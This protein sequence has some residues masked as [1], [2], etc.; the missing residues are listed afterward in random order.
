MKITIDKTNKTVTVHFAE[1]IEEVFEFLTTAGID[2]K[3]YRLIPNSDT[4]FVPVSL[5]L[6]VPS[7]PNY[8]YY[9]PTLPPYQP[10][11]TYRPGFITY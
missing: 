7:Y 8:P 1:N 4:V 3:E 5:P 2:L 10:D 6:P 11:W 9:H